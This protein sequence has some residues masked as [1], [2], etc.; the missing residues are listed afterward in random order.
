M[1]VLGFNKQAQK[2]QDL[3]LFQVSLHLIKY[4]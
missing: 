4:Y 3:F 2:V 1:T